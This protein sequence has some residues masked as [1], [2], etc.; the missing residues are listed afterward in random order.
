MTAANG[1]RPPASN[2]WRMRAHRGILVAVAAAAVLAAAG[3][4]QG[5]VR[6][7]PVATGTPSIAG[8]T[9][10]GRRLTALTG[11]WAGTGSI[12]YGF[13]WYRCDGS[14]ARCNSIRGATAA[15]YMLV[16]KDVAKTIGLMVSA[17]DSA[18]ATRVYPSLVGPIARPTPLLVATAQPIVTG[19]SIQGSTIQASTGA[20][21]PTPSRITYGWL[22]CNVNGRVCGRIADAT[23]SSYTIGPDDVGH[24]LVALV[25]A[26]FGTTSQSA[27]STVT[28][29]AV[30]AEVVG[31]TRVAGPTVNGTAAQGRKLTAAPGTWSGQGPIAFAYQWYRCDAAGA[32][33]NRVRGATRETYTLGKR[34]TGKTL[35]LTL[36]ATDATG[37]A[38][39]YASLIGP[40]AA[41]PAVL[42]ATRQPA[43][44]GD[45]RP[46]QTLVVSQGTWSPAAATSTYAWQRCSASGRL[47]APIAGA[48]DSVYVVTAAD[49]GKGLVAIVTASS[50]GGRQSAF[51]TTVA[52]P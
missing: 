40:I 14:G 44:T 17:A 20:W 29:P 46:G 39:A 6:S 5:S 13:Q 4:S 28:A 38:T 11:T 34:D 24:A 49:A 51:S 31:P 10:V 27:F 26:S 47:C 19:R 21:S 37:T 18:G 43:I 22:R 41:M 15:T 25:Q 48:T 3:T 35:G 9:A 32:R 45:P 23:G 2:A 30:A 42:I 8:T 50:A 1:S 36:R 16:A 52:V 7:G 12:R 33:C